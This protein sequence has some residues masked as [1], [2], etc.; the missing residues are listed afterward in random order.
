LSE[1][2]NLWS[3]VWTTNLHGT[4]RM[5]S[6]R[7]DTLVV[8]GY[9]GNSAAGLYKVAKELGRVLSRLS[10]PLYKAIY[11]DLAKLWGQ[12]D[13][14]RFSRLVVRSS[15][16]AAGGG[17][18]V[19]SGFALFGDYI[20]MLVAGAEYTEAYAVMIWYMLGVV[21]SVA[22]F[23]VTPAALAMG[24]PRLPFYAIAASTLTYFSLLFPFLKIW[25]LQGA[26]IA[27]LS[28]YMAWILY[29][30]SGAVLIEKIDIKS[31]II[32]R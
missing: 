26:G 1:N 5:A 21:V 27:Y 7:L 8:G 22:S 4:V 16:L 30:Y 29:V 6:L 25:G 23:P 19:W 10:Q 3:Y 17:M 2:E 12:E 14:R 15:V 18:L 32:A 31:L 9:L 28:F 20:L 13:H 24:A 11:P